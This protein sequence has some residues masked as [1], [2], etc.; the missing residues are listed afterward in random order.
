MITSERCVCDAH[1]RCVNNCERPPAD[2]LI[3]FTL[4]AGDRRTDLAKNCEP[5]PGNLPGYYLTSEDIARSVLSLATGNLLRLHLPSVLPMHE[6]V[7][8]KMPTIR[9]A[10][11]DVR[12]QKLRIEYY[13]PLYMG[14]S[15]NSRVL[16]DMYHAKRFLT[17]E[18]QRRLEACGYSG[19][20]A[21]PM[22]ALGRFCVVNVPFDICMNVDKDRK[23]TFTGY[24]TPQALAYASDNCRLTPYSRETLRG[25]A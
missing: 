15:A 4:Q 3:L 17:V 10:A 11:R 20:I 16:V 18:D 25:F 6:N 21:I 12:T 24:G 2:A 13:H 14:R 8:N 1:W 9:R 19:A 22:H 7:P 23:A 5:R